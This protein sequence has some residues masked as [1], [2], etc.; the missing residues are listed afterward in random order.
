MNNSKFLRCSMVTV[1]AVAC[2]GVCSPITAHAETHEGWIQEATEGAPV[3]T[4]TWRDDSDYTP[5]ELLAETESMLR[6]LGW[7]EANIQDALKE[8]RKELGLTSSAS[9]SKPT[10]TEEPKKSEPTYTQEQIDA[11]WEEVSKTDATCTEGAKTEYK[12][13]ITGKTKTEVTSDPKGHSYKKEMTVEATCV[14]EG[15]MTYTCTVCGDSYEEVIPVTDVHTYETVTTEATCTLDGHV[16]HTCTVCGDTYE[17]TLPALGHK[18]GE[19]VVTKKPGLFTEGASIVSCDTCNEVLKEDTL[20]QT[21]PLTL[22]STIIL[23]AIFVAVA[24][25]FSAAMV[26][27]M[28]TAGKRPD[29]RKAIA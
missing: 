21:F 1:A 13:S 26:R 22:K 7:S 20:P 16:T 2:F 8:K 12:N 19:V 24:G 9:T 5:E 18:A 17:E 3:T 27:K 15:T 29:K 14:N 10:K 4:F 11:A 28:N 23:G 25:M 6:E